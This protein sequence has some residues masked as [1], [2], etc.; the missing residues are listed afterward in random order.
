MTAGYHAGREFIAF[1]D[2][3]V[4]RTRMG[5]GDPRGA[6]SVGRDSAGLSL[7]VSWTHVLL[8][9]LAKAVI[10]GRHWDDES[11]T[12]VRPMIIDDFEMRKLPLTTAEGILEPS[13][14]R[15]KI[16]AGC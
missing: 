16:G 10:G 1:L 3:L 15:S 14:V 5:H 2:G 9:E 8:N 12:T 13:T 4:A 11:L 7:G 6:P